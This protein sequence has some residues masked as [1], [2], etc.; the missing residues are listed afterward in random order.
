MLISCN[1]GNS[2]YAK[3]IDL[4]KDT[5]HRSNIS[6]TEI[7]KVINS[8]SVSNNIKYE[9]EI[10]KE[11]LFEETE[12][13]Y[14]YSLK[15]KKLNSSEI[16]CHFKKSLEDSLIINRID[17]INEIKNTHYNY[18]GKYGY[19][20]TGQLYEKN[21]IRLIIDRD[22]AKYAGFS[23]KE[24]KNNYFDSGTTKF[25]LLNRNGIEEPYQNYLYNL[26][27]EF[28]LYPYEENR[29][30]KI[31]EFSLIVKLLDDID[32]GN[33]KYN[34]KLDTSLL[35][36]ANYYGLV[37]LVLILKD[38]G[39]YDRGFVSENTIQKIHINDYPKLKVLVRFDYTGRMLSKR[40]ELIELAKY[41]YNKPKDPIGFQTYYSSG[42]G[43]IEFD[44]KYFIIMHDDGFESISHLFSIWKK[45][46]KSLCL[47]SIIDT[48]I[49]VGIGGVSVKD[50]LKIG[51]NKYLVIGNTQ[52]GDGG[53]SWG[54]FW[55]GILSMPDSLD[56]V[57]EKHCSGDEMRDEYFENKIISSDSIIVLYKKEK[58]YDSNQDILLSID[59]INY[60]N[61]AHN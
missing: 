10:G 5:I 18:E 13:K 36:K 34:Y 57:Y 43:P 30:R 60:Y 7:K 1:T 29:S 59:T 33:F 2:N 17:T 3:S 61:L 27:D 49:K 24:T 58:H 40:F 47:E 25:P 22:N 53:D 14:S 54:S 19:M 9:L 44:G 31:N 11:E 20:C 41:S 46:G 55:L 21:D 51:F 4:V 15:L 56:L 37:N 45:E 12:G 26:I 8:D 48:T 6:D 32:K 35:D 38:R 50:I 52:G 23:I 39:I 42:I 28:Q 16:R